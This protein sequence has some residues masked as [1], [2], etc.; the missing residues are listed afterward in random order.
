MVTCGPLSAAQ[1]SAARLH[2][3]E[4][5]SSG[6]E[7]LDRLIPAGGVRRGSLLEWLGDGEASG[8]MAVACAVACRLS[9]SLNDE[10]ATAAPTVV[11]VDRQ[12]RFYPPAVM[13]WLA[14]V[15]SSVSKEPQLVV[16]RASSADDE[17]WAIDQALRCRGVAAVLAC[18]QSIQPTTMRRW[19]LAARG[20]QAVG[21]FVR[22][23]A[24][25]GQQASRRQ[26]TWAEARIA[27]SPLPGESLAVRRLRLTLVGGPWAG[28]ASVEGR[29]V[30]IGIDL[31]RGCGLSRGGQPHGHEA[32]GI[33]MFRPHAVPAAEA[34]ACRAS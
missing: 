29:A 9:G 15:A 21:L 32:G 7:P 26:P 16:A 19:Q 12:G 22:P 18:P 30:E 25:G 27:V 13:G 8:A 10:G 17:A 2:S 14:N 23:Q 20:S 4:V 28:E 34:V 11:V 6:F 31:S 33:R 1:F 24:A 3:G 5:V